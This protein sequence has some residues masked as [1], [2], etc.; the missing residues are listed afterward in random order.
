[1]NNSS[2]IIDGK[3]RADARISQV[4]KTEFTEVE[5]TFLKTQPAFI[6]AV[7]AAQK[8][9]DLLLNLEASSLC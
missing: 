5:L 2:S 6:N 4:L 9:E 7:N 8:I 1:L 3:F